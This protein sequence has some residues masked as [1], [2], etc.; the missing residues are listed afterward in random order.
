MLIDFIRVITYLPAGLNP[1]AVAVNNKAR[2]DLGLHGLVCGA[3]AAP[4]D[5]PETRM[6]AGSGVKKVKMCPQMCPQTVKD[7]PP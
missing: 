5:S 4:K 6:N 7:T 2:E 1:G 3:E